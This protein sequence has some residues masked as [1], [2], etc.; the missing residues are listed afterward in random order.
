MT[1]RTLILAI[2]LQR[3]GN[4]AILGWVESLFPTVTFH[5]DQSHDLFADEAGLRALLE[6]DKAACTIISFED[7][8]NRTQ[9]PGA[10]L[11]DSLSPA[12]DWLSTEYDLH[13]LV[14]LRDPYNTWASRVAANARAKEFG[15]P[16]TSDPSWDLYRRNWMALAALRSDPNWTLALFNAWKED[17]AY[18]QHL[19]AELG[20]SYSEE[21]LDQVSHRGGGS[22]F[23]GVPRPSYGGMLK[24]W[25]KYVSGPFLKRLLAK[26]GHY[27]KRF[28]TPPQ[29]GS[30]M[31]V[32]TR[33]KTLEGQSEAAALFTDQDLQEATRVIFGPDTVPAAT[34][35]AQ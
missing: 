27:V 31:A 12:P 32:D 4:H 30:A 21:A 1:K 16:L 17:A 28:I 9:T 15:N 6:S 24:K 19:C 26:P 11:R 8:A 29:T 34:R 23:E 2:G 14:I 10:L 33:W 7:S 25:R 13:R 22:S 18:R 35:Q 5:N 3:S 20:G